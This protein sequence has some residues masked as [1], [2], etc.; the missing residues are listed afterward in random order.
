MNEEK[1]YS[2][3]SYLAVTGCYVF[4]LFGVH[5]FYLGNNKAGILRLVLMLSVIGSP[6]TL[7]LFIKDGILLMLGKLADSEGNYVRYPSFKERYKDSQTF[8]NKTM[9]VTGEMDADEK[10][11]KVNELKER[12]RQ[13]GDHSPSQSSQEKPDE[14]KKSDNLLNNV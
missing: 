10:T 11:E 8:V 12:I 13:K 5:Q 2:D 14:K 9:G 6:V 3:K 1:I 4:G 7:I